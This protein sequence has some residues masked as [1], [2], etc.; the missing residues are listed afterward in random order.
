MTVFC[1]FLT[2]FNRLRLNNLPSV[3]YLMWIPSWQLRKAFVSMTENIILNRVGARTQPCL[4]PLVS[5][6]ENFHHHAI[7]KLPNDCREFFLGGWGGG[8]G[9][10]RNFSMICRRPSLLNVN[11][12]KCFGQINKGHVEV[13]M[14]FLAFCPGVDAKQKSFPPSPFQLRSCI[15][16]LGENLP[17]G[18]GKGG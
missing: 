15:G 17:Q 16:F 12:N 3:L 10:R 1:T 9:F 5:I 13:L 14:L 4:T 8:W 6:I 7:V 11:R 2:A 18:V